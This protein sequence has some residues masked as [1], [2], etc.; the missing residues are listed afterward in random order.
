M[1][2]FVLCFT[3]H[4][5]DDSYRECLMRLSYRLNLSLIAG[6]AVTSLA[7]TFYQTIMETRG[8]RAEAERHAVVLAE[9]LEKS[10]QPLLAKGATDQ[11]QKL[12][13]GFD[14]T[15]G[16]AG[17]AVYDASG[18]PLAVTSTFSESLPANFRPVL[19]ALGDGLLRSD[20]RRMGKLTIHTLALPLRGDNAI[21]GAIGIFQDVSYIDAQA[22]AIWR[23]ALLHMAIQTFFI[24]CITMLIIRLSLRRP[25]THMAQWL[26]DMRTGNATALPLTTEKVFE[27]I[28]TE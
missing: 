6:V 28:T 1:A 3:S 16:L 7:F 17:I 13:D 10:V 24:V 21:I 12:S 19:E 4:V 8:L 15:S 5:Q 20:F 11:L 26:R 2:P 9:S 27:P 22:V 18:L 14:R 23:R 25:L